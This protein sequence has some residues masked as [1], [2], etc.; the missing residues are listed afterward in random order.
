MVTKCSHLVHFEYNGTLWDHT[1][2]EIAGLRG[3]RWLHF[4]V[5]L[6]NAIILDFVSDGDVIKKQLAADVALI[7][8]K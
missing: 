4:L 2:R 7:T 6:D 3:S 8:R 5:N 1:I